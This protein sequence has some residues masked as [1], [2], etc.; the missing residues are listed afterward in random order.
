[1]IKSLYFVI[2]R[3]QNNYLKILYIIIRYIINLME[4]KLTYYFYQ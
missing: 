2:V 3:M 1:M 4:L